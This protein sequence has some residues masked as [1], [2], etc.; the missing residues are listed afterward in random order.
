G[1]ARR[2]ADPQRPRAGGFG[3]LGAEA[4]RVADQRLARAVALLGMRS[5]GHDRGDHLRGVRADRL[6]P[7]D[8]ALRWPAPILLVILG[9]VRLVGH[10]RAPGAVAAAM[11][12]DSTAAEK[13]LHGRDRHAG[14]DV[15]A[16]QVMRDAVVP[17]LVLDVVVDAD[18]ELLPQRDLEA[19]P[20]QRLEDRLVER[21]VKR[22]T[23]ALELL[24]GSIIEALEQF[25]DRDVEF[26]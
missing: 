19:R 2:V 6:G 4:L 14:V 15:L 17:A 24:E 20:G 23:T 7:A 9:S 10:L 3:P 1:L 22:A 25:G 8:Q 5:R 26:V 18:A 21:L 12:S 11:A 13:Q 16:A